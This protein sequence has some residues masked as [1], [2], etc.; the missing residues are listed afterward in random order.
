MAFAEAPSDDQCRDAHLAKSQHKS[1]T[2]A[3]NSIGITVPQ[4]KSRIK[5]Y[6]NRRLGERAS[7]ETDEIVF[8]DLP[9]SELPAEDL[10]AQACKRFESHLSARDARRWMEIKVKSNKPMAICF[11]GDPHIDN[12]GCNWPL[13]QARHRH[14]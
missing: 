5:L 4:L 10:I 1:Q 6:E 7:I 13:L 2:E 12:N 8:P 3:A 9:S 14:S 11:M